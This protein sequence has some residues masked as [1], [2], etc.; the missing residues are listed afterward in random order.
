MDLSS[1]FMAYIEQHF[2]RGFFVRLM[3]EFELDYSDALDFCLR[4]F[5]R[6]EAM[7]LLPYERRARNETSLRVVARE[8]E[9]R[10]ITAS[11]VPNITNSNYHTE[12]VSGPVV[13]T[14]SFVQNS[15]AVVRMADFRGTLAQNKQQSLIAPQPSSGDRFYALLIHGNKRIEKM[16]FHG[17]LGFFEL[18]IPNDL[19][20]DY[21]DTPANL[22]ARYANDDVDPADVE[23]TARNGVRYEHARRPS[24]LLRE[25]RKLQG[26]GS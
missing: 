26:Y 20:N 4:R 6:E 25:Y 18:A 11:A 8:F 24:T 23:A 13:L 17:A 14:A 5:E 7:D 9:H 19:C 15:R 21:L 10:G 1:E 22:A 12:V 3:E 16:R 2:P